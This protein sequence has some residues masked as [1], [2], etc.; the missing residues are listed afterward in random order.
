M[1]ELVVLP[2]IGNIAARRDIE[3]VEKNGVAAD[4]ERGLD[5]AA[6]AWIDVPRRFV[7]ESEKLYS[8]W[9]YRNNDWRKSNRGRR[10]DHILA[11]PA[12][13]GAIK[14]HH[15][16]IDLRDWKLASDHVPVL[17]TFEV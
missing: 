13:S 3:I 1:S 7:P 14:N 8:W 4:I 9:S 11:S 10:L 2:G 15:I 12:L 16:D 6:M 5:M 17:A